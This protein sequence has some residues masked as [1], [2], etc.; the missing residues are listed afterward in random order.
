MHKEEKENVPAQR[1]I[2]IFVFTDPMMG[3]SYEHEPVLMQLRQEYREKLGIQY[4]M[5][6]LV[7]DVSDFMTTEERML[8]A[9]EGIRQ[10]NSRLAGIYLDEIPVGNLPMNMENFHL[11]D[12][13]HRSSW[14]LDIAFEAVRLINPNK[15]DEFLY[16]LR[17]TTILEG[18][19]TTKTEVLADV[20]ES[21]GV[22]RKVF[23]D[24]FEDGRAEECFREDLD[25]ARMYQVHSL[26][27]YLIRGEEK[28]VLINGMPDFRQFQEL[29]NKV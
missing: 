24:C 6:G 3:L 17:Q 27:S 10:Y 9:K 28:E 20:A 16:A 1:S 12:P 5:S 14:P 26:P 29:I 21:V 13:E 23:L 19:Q 2:T 18:K 15:A 11:F 8:P 4:V 25:M 22:D 7:R